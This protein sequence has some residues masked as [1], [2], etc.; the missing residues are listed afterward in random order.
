[1]SHGAPSGCNRNTCFWNSAQNS[2][3]WAGLPLY[4]NPHFLGQV[5]TDPD[6]GFWWSDGRWKR[7]YTRYEEREGGSTEW[8]T[9]LTKEDSGYYATGTPGLD[10]QDETSTADL[11]FNGRVRQRLKYTEYHWLFNITTWDIGPYHVHNLN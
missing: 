3:F 1:M 11:H 6:K 7:E 9:V 5:K 2:G 8:D 10:E 4:Q